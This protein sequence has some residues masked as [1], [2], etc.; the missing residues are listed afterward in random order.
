MGTR[1]V[2]KAKNSATIVFMWKS[3]KFVQIKKMLK[4]V[5]SNNST[6]ECNNRIKILG[7]IEFQND[8][9]IFTL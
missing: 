6:W 8:S 3:R 4:V 1:G 9:N 7:W 2:T 5:Y